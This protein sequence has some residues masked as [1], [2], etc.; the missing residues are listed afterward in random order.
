MERQL[1]SGANLNVLPFK[2]K[3][4]VIIKKEEKS[5]IVK[6]KKKSLDR[7]YYIISLI[8]L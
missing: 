5:V 7:T 1:E 4:S 3:K 6:K 2:N 8:K